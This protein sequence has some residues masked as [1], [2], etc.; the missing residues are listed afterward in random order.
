MHRNEERDVRRDADE[1][2]SET[3]SREADGDDNEPVGRCEPP[4]HLCALITAS[5][6]CFKR[7]LVLYQ[8][9]KLHAAFR[10]MRRDLA[11]ARALLGELAGAGEKLADPRL[12]PRVGFSEGLDCPDLCGRQR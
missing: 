5:D 4:T 11:C 8:H 7:G 1:K 10:R 9:V 3:A 6:L 12:V 2:S